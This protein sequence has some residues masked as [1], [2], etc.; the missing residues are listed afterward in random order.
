MLNQLCT[1]TA[2]LAP[3]LP[4]T[5]IRQ[6]AELKYQ[7]AS[8]RVPGACVGRQLAEQPPHIA[9]PLGVIEMQKTYQSYLENINTDINRLTRFIKFV[10]L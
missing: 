1:R 7:P 9:G 6:L 3:Y 2:K 10:P 5:V 8:W 4:C